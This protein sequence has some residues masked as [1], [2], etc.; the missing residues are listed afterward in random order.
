M[1]ACSHT[2]LKYTTE[3]RKS[4]QVLYSCDPDAQLLERFN[5]LDV[6]FQL[7]AAPQHG[8][9]TVAGHTSPV[10]ADTACTPCL[11][12]L[13]HGPVPEL[14]DLGTAHAALHALRPALL[15]S[16]GQSACLCSSEALPV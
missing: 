6:S 1:S 7:T 15:C 8:N 11:L 10:A 16:A 12:L 2:A 13:C 14:I 9:L 4:A 3:D 5:P